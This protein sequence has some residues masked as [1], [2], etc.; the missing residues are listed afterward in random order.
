MK[1]STMTP[2]PIDMGDGPFAIEVE[3]V[4]RRFEETQ[5]LD[6]L[7]LAVPEGAVY[8][9]VGPNGAG[10]TTLL[11]ML[12]GLGARDSG[13]L[14]VHGMDPAARGAE[15]RANVGYVPEHQRLGYPWLTVGRYLEHCARLTPGWD[16]EYAAR[17]CRDFDVDLSKRCDSLSKGQTR[18]V[19]IIAAL[20]SRPAVLLL[21][22]PTDGLDHVIRDVMLGVLAEHF[23]DSPTTALISTHRVYEIERLVDHVGVLRRGRLLGQMPVDDLRGKLRRYWGT[24]PED[25]ELSLGSGQRVVRT[26]RGPADAEWTVW[27]EEQDVVAGLGRAG[28]TVRDVAPL[29]LDE[30]ATALLS[31][32][33][34]S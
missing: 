33:E 15:V 24:A 26:I 19:Q 12:M 3:G 2:L 11:T 25:F 34:I 5:A 31:Q 16:R 10:K 20:A 21:D 28:A 32:R 14:R 22:E 4:S 29:S 6:D 17:L 9:L 23:A 18:R 7:A 27:G 1:V 8:V 30:A 13:S